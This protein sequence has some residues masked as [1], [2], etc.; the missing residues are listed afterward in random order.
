MEPLQVIDNETEE[1]EN[2]KRKRK[3]RAEKNSEELTQ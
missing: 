2:R 3:R 1:E